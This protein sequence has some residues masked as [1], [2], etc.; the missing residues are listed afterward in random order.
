MS[1]RIALQQVDDTR[2]KAVLDEWTARCSR[3]GIRNPEAHL[4]GI[5]QRVIRGEFNV[6]AKQAEPAPP[7]SVSTP[8]T[9]REAPTKAVSREGA[10]AHCASE[11]FASQAVDCKLSAGS[12]TTERHGG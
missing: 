9:P 3:H 4:F 7:A 10:T 12:R 8:A 11:R 6:W 2:R 1:A 5:I